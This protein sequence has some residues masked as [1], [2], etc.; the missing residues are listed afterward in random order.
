MISSDTRARLARAAGNAVQNNR[1]LHSD[2]RAAA[3]R[4]AEQSGGRYTSEQIEEQMRLMGSKNRGMPADTIEQWDVARQPGY[5]IDPGLPTQ[6][7]TGT[8]QVIEVPG[9][10]D[11]EIQQFIISNT[12]TGG[13]TDGVP[14]WA[15]YTVSRDAT[16]PINTSSVASIA[17]CANG[18]CLVYP[19]WVCN[20]NLH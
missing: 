6:A 8:T 4:L 16:A 20:R 14:P 7:V 1:M 9:Q 12:T 5:S 19:E 15:P 11:W 2:E 13:G 3:R 10:A 18:A 17:R